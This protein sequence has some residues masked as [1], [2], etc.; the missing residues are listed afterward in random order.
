MP[1]QYSGKIHVSIRH[2]KRKN[3]D[4]YVLE[5]TTQYDREKKL[6]RTLKTR[7]LGKI[8]AGET[9]MVGTRAKKPNGFNKTA[10]A[11]QHCGMTD[12]L[13]WVGRESGIDE[14]VRSCFSPGD[15]DKMISIARYWLATEGNTLPRLEGWQITHSLPYSHGI[16]E[17]VYGELFKN[18]GYQEERIQK[19][20][21]CR[22]GRL[23][24]APV[25]AYD[26][27]T[28]STYSECQN[29]ARHGFNKEHDGLP[30]IK[31]LTLYSIKDSEPIAFAKQSGN[32]PDVIAIDNALEQLKCFD[33]EKPVVVTD[34]GYCSIDNLQKFC[35][36]NMKFL[37]LIDRHTKMAQTAID[38]VRS[39]LNS[40]AAS[41]PFDL[42]I[43]GASIMKMHTFNRERQ[44]NGKNA[45]R[46]DVETMERR[47]YFHVFYSDLLASQ[48]R[49]EF[50][51]QLR[52][53][54]A[55]LE[56]GRTDFTEA[57]QKR[58]EKY[59]VLSK[60]GRGGHLHIDFNEKA[61][62]EAQNY[63]GYFVLVGNCACDTFDALTD[64]R[65]REKIEELFKCEKECADSKRVRVWYGD[66]LRGRQMVQFISICYRCFLMK[67]IKQVENSLAR[68]T[69]MLTTTQAEL[70]RKLKT[71]IQQRSLAQILD[72]FD[73]VDKVTVNTEAGKRRWTTEQIER[74]KEFLMKLG[75]IK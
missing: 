62:A 5:R 26:S 29:E 34:N 36:R 68:D 49:L 66:T 48:H 71:W 20:F 41:C 43:S 7:L 61:C 21:Y 75:V 42:N 37:T 28:I 56:G 6:T 73:C 53:L 3:G 17:D 24:R 14:D 22:A 52:E 27:T 40:M 46:G 18:L 11:R 57:A 32:I 63:F 51:K 72:W 59:L 45:K 16:S 9:E 31:L 23:S 65:L 25:I 10:S 74:D 39:S 19:Y 55:Q 2:E 54:K 38:E 58:I 64:Y 44:R 13:E 8:P 50:K 12:I 69:S 35:Q 47:L 67:R 70:E 1:R 15:A 33:I 60:Q 4:I 30:T